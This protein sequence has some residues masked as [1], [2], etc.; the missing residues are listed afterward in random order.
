MA[1]SRATLASQYGLTFNE[2][3]SYSNYD[4]IVAAQVAQYNQGYNTYAANMAALDTEYNT[5]GMTDEEYE[6]RKKAI[7]EEW[8]AKQKVYEDF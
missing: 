4:D 3:G 2:D 8:E 1:T 7:E 5:T 6:R